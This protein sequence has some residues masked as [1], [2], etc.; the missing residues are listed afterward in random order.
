MSD[1]ARLYAENE[2]RELISADLVVCGSEYVRECIARI[3]DG[4][5]KCK[6]VPYG[7]QSCD[8]PLDK[9]AAARRCLHVLFAGTLCLRKGIQYFAECA[10]QMTGSA[11]FMAVGTC[12]LSEKGQQEVS[13]YVK[14]AGPV[15]RTSMNQFWQWA[16]VLVLPSL[17]EGSATVTYEALSAGVPVVCT[18]ESGSA[19]RNVD[20]GFIVESRS[21]IAVLEKLQ[22][23]A[24]DRDLLATM[25][26]SARSRREELSLEGYHR[27]LIDCVTNEVL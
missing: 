11:E 19:V 9:P 7:V 16:D 26:I 22:K 2:K 15:P 12:L 5:A 27:R 14:I 18:R 8:K 3:T 10:R 20:D 6:V 24:S 17:C 21:S 1:T 13:R 4:A 23:L 25:S